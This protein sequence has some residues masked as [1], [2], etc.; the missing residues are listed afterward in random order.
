MPRLR[1]AVLVSGFA[2]NA[3]GEYAH[4]ATR[5][6][7]C[8][9]C[10]SDDHRSNLIDERPFRQAARGAKMLRRLGHMGAAG[11][12]LTRL[13]SVKIINFLRHRFECNA[14]GS[15]FDE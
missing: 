15:Q 8:P 1:E 13:A 6:V 14:C 7:I 3:H 11:D 5:I 4:E 9:N 10:G 2:A 12:V